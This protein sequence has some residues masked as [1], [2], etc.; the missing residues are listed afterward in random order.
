MLETLRT[1]LASVF[2]D[3]RRRIIF[4]L[5]VQGVIFTGLWFVEV[6]YGFRG[7]DQIGLFRYGNDTH[8]YLDPILPLI[9]ED[10]FEQNSY[11]II[12]RYLGV[13]PH[14]I[15][16]DARYKNESFFCK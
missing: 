9:F 11:D 6:N 5:I 1:S 10:L 12:W 3:H 14:G 8:S 2:G 16:H 15:I 4:F 13:R 7:K